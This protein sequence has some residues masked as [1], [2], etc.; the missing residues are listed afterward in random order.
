MTELTQKEK[1]LV[2]VCLGCSIA[3]PEQSDIHAEVS[4][5]YDRLRLGW[6]ASPDSY[7]TAKEIMDKV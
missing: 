1:E 5:L 3:D 6:L 4:N 2:L 7:H